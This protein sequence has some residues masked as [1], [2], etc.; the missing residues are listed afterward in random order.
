MRS[1]RHCLASHCAVRYGSAGDHR[2]QQ[3]TQ[4]IHDQMAVAPFN[5]LACIKAQR[6]AP[7]AATVGLGVD[8]GFTGLPGALHTLSPLLGQ[9]LVQRFQFALADPAHKSLLHRLPRRV[10][11]GGQV[12]PGRSGAQ[13]V[14]AHLDHAAPGVRCRPTSRAGLWFEQVLCQCPFS[15]CEDE[16]RARVTAGAMLAV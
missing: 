9:T 12:A 13:H 14:A 2:R 4:R 15:V 7:R 11:L 16:G 3:Q 5:L 6:S 8:H 10:D 1:L